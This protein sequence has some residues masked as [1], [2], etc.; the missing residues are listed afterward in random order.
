MGQHL[1]TECILGA[2]RN[3]GKTVVLATQQLQ[4]LP[5]ADKILVLD[6]GGKQLFFGTFSELLGEPALL[7]EMG[8]E[9]MAEQRSKESMASLPDPTISPELRSSVEPP[10]PV[11][12]EHTVTQNTTSYLSAFPEQRSSECKDALPVP[13]SHS[14]LSSSAKPPSP[15]ASVS[16]IGNTNTDLTVPDAGCSL[17][18]ENTKKNANYQP[19]L[20]LAALTPRSN[21]QSGETTA[22]HAVVE[23]EDRATGTVTFRTYYTYLTEGGGLSGAVAL[24]LLASAQVVLMMTDYWLRWWAQGAYGPQGRPMYLYTFA[25]LVTLVVILGYLRAFAWFR[26][27]LRASSQLHD[28]CLWAVT[29]S[30]LQ[31]FVSNPTGRILNR[32]TKDQYLVDEFLPEV[33]FDCL[34]IFFFCLAAIVLIFIAI[35]WLSV[36]SPLLIFSFLWVRRKYIASARELK[37]LESI[38]RSPVVSDFSASLE[39]LI[40]LQTFGL[41]KRVTEM[42]HRQV[43]LNGR[44]FFTLLMANRWL[45]LRLDV[46]VSTVLTVT[47]FMAVLLRNTIDPGLIGFALVYNL[48]LTAL[49]QW[50]VRQSAEVENQ[51]TSVER[52]CYYANLVPEQGYKTTYEDMVLEKEKIS[53]PNRSMRLAP[54]KDE[55]DDLEETRPPTRRSLITESFFD[56]AATVN[57]T[58]EIRNMSVKYKEEFDPVLTNINLSIM[59]GSKVGVCGRTGSGK[60]SLLLALLRLNIISEGDVLLDGR[61]LLSMDLEVVRGIISIIPQDAHLFSGTIRYNLDPF[62]TYS[63]QELWAALEDAQIKNFIA[64]SPLGLQAVVTEGGK[65]FSVGQRQL[66]SL[67]RCILRQS[68]I[69]LMDEVTASIDYQM[70]KLIQQTI[71]EAPAL[72]YSTIVTVAHRLR[73]IADSDMVVVI[74]EGRVVET[75]APH[76]LLTNTDSHFRALV[77]KSNEFEEIFKIARD[78]R[79][80]PFTRMI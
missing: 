28:K 31:F 16:E 58:L 5:L 50:G 71:R 19:E 78:A 60:S 8:L 34:Q 74:Q 64:Q 44:A 21:N 10:L 1:M 61:S 33:S 72:K 66:L 70:D 35:P 65:N 30:P 53:D 32:F 67:A 37:R 51:M 27:S 41:R 4:H 54:G 20:S 80:K 23:A 68:R 42:F 57:G 26:F 56:E 29:H 12:A 6:V 15:D 9:A 49:F 36:L 69:V 77:D 46:G 55:D 45:G 7:S 63:D 13:I 48:S 24:L 75:G 11:V 59:G 47:V 2:L 39:G 62:S 73:T 25:Q 14:E 76:D 40:T 43:D 79:V 18:P 3:R 38:S 22:R 52:I 17:F